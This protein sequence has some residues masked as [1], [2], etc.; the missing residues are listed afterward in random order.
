MSEH[1]TVVGNDSNENINT[2]QRVYAN[3]NSGVRGVNIH[4]AHREAALAVRGPAVVSVLHGMCNM[5]TKNNE[6]SATG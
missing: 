1:E 5:Q 3:A 4:R 6:R 2:V